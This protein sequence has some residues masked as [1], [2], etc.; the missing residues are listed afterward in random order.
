MGA[1]LVR[2]HLIKHQQIG[3]AAI[4]GPQQII[5]TMKAA[6]PPAPGVQDRLQQ[7]AESLVVV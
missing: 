2:Q 5:G 7:A 3:G 4:E 1:G 6:G